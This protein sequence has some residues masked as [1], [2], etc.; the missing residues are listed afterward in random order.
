MSW[1]GL[2]GSR[3]GFYSLNTAARAGAF[4]L[5]VSPQGLCNASMGG[6]GENAVKWCEHP[7]THMVPSFAADAIWNFFRQ[8]FGRSTRAY[9]T[10]ELPG[11]RPEVPV[12]P[13]GYG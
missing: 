6:M 11:S 8:F 2:T 1:H 5:M 7:G 12:G 9:H 13:S 4:A 3:G 10:A